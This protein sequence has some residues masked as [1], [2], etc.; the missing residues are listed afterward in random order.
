LAAVVDNSSHERDDTGSYRIPI[1]VQFAWAIVLIVGMFLLPETP[2]YLIRSDKPDQ[3]AVSLGMLRSLPADHP[4]VQ[5]EL[6]EIKANHEYELSLGSSSYIDCFRGHMLKRQLTGM[7][8]QALQ[9][10][11]GKSKKRDSSPLSRLL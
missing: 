5:E 4:A 2:R 9:Q 11:T 7:G 10:L 6:E 8:L 1:A 3:A